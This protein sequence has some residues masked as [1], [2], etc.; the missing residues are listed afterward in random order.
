MHDSR[1]SEPQSHVIDGD[2]GGMDVVEQA[3]AYARKA[4]EFR[5]AAIKK[6]LHQREEI[7]AR[8][9]LLGYVGTPNGHTHI[10]SPK[11]PLVR[12]NTKRFRDVHLATAA[13]TLLEEYGTLHGK[14]IEEL[15]KAGGFESRI[16]NFQNYLP[17]ALKRAGGF[18][19]VG[20]NTWQLNQGIQP[21]KR[22]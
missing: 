17:V 21:K 18:E 9:K 14:K 13:K 5:A 12:A 11:E 20:G 19:N 8:L 1:E 3:L 6:L 10:V 2:H 7:E 15:L 4:D 16:D 22:N